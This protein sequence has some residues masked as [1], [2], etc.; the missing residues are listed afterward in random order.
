VFHIEKLNS[1]FDEIIKL[2]EPDNVHFR[3]N[4]SMISL[5]EDR[6]NNEKAFYS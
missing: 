5:F 3:L 6:I 4:F 2:S 1:H